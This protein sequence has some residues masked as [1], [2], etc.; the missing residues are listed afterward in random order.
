MKRLNYKRA[1]DELAKP[2]YEKLPAQALSFLLVVASTYGETHQAQDLGMDELPGI[3][4]LLSEMKLED[5]SS[6]SQ[7]IYAVGHWAYGDPLGKVIQESGTYWKV[8]KLMDQEIARRLFRKVPRGLEYAHFDGRVRLSIRQGLELWIDSGKL[9]LSYSTNWA[10]GNVFG[11]GTPT[12]EL[13]ADVCAVLTDRP[14]AGQSRTDDWQD[15]MCARA[16]AVKARHKGE[17]WD[18]EQFM[19]VEDF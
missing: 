3:R 10:F 2:A 14:V 7:T 8:S 9:N 4:K 19:Q 15:E 16:E 17:V 13:V 1:W 18:T 6:W 11:I 12:H 5:L